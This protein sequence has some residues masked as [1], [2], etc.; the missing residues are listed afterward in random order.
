MIIRAAR[1]GEHAVLSGIAMAAKAHWG[2][3]AEAMARWRPGL[4]VTARSIAQQPSVLAEL[5]TRIAGFFQ[6]LPTDTGIELDHLWV[7]PV[8]MR[9]GVGRA[10][11]AAALQT[12]DEL[13]YD[14]LCIDADPAAEGFYLAAGA[15]RIGAVAAPIAGHPRRIRPQLRLAV[16]PS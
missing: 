7:L 3:P 14:A 10:L 1:P 12:A 15:V 6:L 13:G 9:R 8:F 11:L 5:N 4:T 2:Y 16:R